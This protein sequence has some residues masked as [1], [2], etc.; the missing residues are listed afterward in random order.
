[1]NAFL[2]VLEKYDIPRDALKRGNLNTLQVNL[3]NL[4]NQSCRHC[5]IGASPEGRSIMPR[6]VADSILSFL[7]RNDIR[8]LDITGGSPELNPNFDYLVTGARDFVREL[9]VRSNL[10][11]FF[12]VSKEYLPAFFRENRVH[13]ICSMPCYTKENVDRQRGVGVFEKSIEALRL[14][15]AE[16]YAKD[17]ALN[18]DLVYN[19]QGAYLPASQK[20]LE[21]DYKNALRKSCGVE[22]SRLITITNVAIKRFR[23]YL[24]EN[25]EYEKYSSILRN[26][27][28]PKTLEALMCRT[29]LSVGFDGK[30]YDCDFNLALGLA[31]KD[32]DG[33]PLSID[34][35]NAKD[36]NERI[37][38]TGEHCL[39]CTAGS[40][41]SCQGALTG[42]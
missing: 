17:S 11:V 2:N 18:I 31:L 26:S 20:E 32:R 38:V 9:I 28:N 21:K 10:T 19:P 13:L 33:N 36:L 23:E 30:V 40:G 34:R 3:G 6:K 5:H 8:T 27:F 35:I 39:A 25:N 42:F 24:E 22:F 4:C 14:L 1:M 7:K 41:S 16:G 12:V 29:F 15:N 37:V